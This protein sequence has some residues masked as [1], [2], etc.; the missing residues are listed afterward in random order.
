MV[1]CRQE[2]FLSLS[3]V[4]FMTLGLNSKRSLTISI[5]SWNTK[6]LTLNCIKSIYQA[7]RDF[8]LRIIV[9][10]NNSSDGSVAA[11]RKAYPEVLV[12]ENETNKGFAAANNQALAVSDSDFFLLLNPDTIVSRNSLKGMLDFLVQ[13]PKVG[14]AGPRLVFPDGSLQKGYSTQFPSLAMI[15]SHHGLLKE[16]GPSH[17]TVL[18]KPTP[19]G[20]LMGACLMLRRKAIED[21]GPMDEA[22]FLIYEDADWCHRLNKSGWLIYYLPQF[23]VV[24][25]QGQSE[26]LIPGKGIIETQ[27]SLQYYLR[28]HYGILIA[29][30]GTLL[31]I[32]IHSIWFIKN[33]IKA[34][35]FGDSEQIEYRR[36][37]D[38]YVLLGQILG[39]KYF[40]SSIMNRSGR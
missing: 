27:I 23:T 36:A 39:I 33:E 21:V 1:G 35:V 18:E 14:A 13:H 22:F 10:D 16:P 19:V 32:S 6:N 20:C 34:L 25:Y 12:L 26:K 2:V 24:H 3:V 40:L 4:M 15:L 31:M 9:V 28:K 37:I 5:V 38:K 8:A 11:I 7:E 17:K 30:L 29:V